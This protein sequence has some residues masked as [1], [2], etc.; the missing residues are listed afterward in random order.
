MSGNIKVLLIGAGYMSRE[1]IKILTDMN[2]PFT[3]IGKSEK[4]VQE[5]RSIYTGIHII[6]GGI[7]NF[8]EYADYTHAIVAVNVAQLYPVTLCLINN[9]IKNILC[10]KPIVLYQNNLDTLA[11]ACIKKQVNL[12]AAYNRRFYSSVSELKKQV[13]KDGGILSCHFE[14]TEWIHRI[15]PSEFTTEELNRWII[16][17]SSHVID[18]AFHLI[19]KPELLNSHVAGQ[20][21][22]EWHPNGTVFIGSG[23]SEYNIPFTYHS[24]WNSAGRWSIEVL[25]SGNKYFLR[26][27]EGL[28]KQ[29]KGQL[30]IEDIS[31]ENE[32]DVKYKPGNYK[33]VDA[34]LNDKPKNTLCEMNEFTQLFSSLLK[35]GDYQK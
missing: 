24:N 23:V 27:L 26:P 4:N 2:I 5:T 31:I 10:E 20:N 21:K 7:E 16:S 18:L 25:T 17:N 11:D 34:F 12:Y 8:K 14:F 9:G 1:Y 3:V 6:S 30:T 33:M 35:I 15:N 28:Q 19:G 29:K 32:L 22:I 13:E